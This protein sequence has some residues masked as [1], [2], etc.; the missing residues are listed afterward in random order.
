MVVIVKAVWLSAV[1]ASGG[2]LH[3][4]LSRSYGGQEERVLMVFVGDKCFSASALDELLLVV[5]V[6]SLS[7]FQAYKACLLYTSPSPRDWSASRMPS[8][9]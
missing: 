5:S 7:W 9:A 6:Y 1:D 4:L 8:S 2:R 3:V